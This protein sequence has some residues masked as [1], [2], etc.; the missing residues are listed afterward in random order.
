MIRQLSSLALAAAL[1]APIALADR[2][3]RADR[4]RAKLRASSPTSP[5]PTRPAPSF[6][7]NLSATAPACAPARRSPARRDHQQAQQAQAPGV[8]QINLFDS[9]RESYF[10]TT[11]TIPVGTTIQ[12]FI[13]QPDFKQEWGLEALRVTED[14]SPGFSLVLP[15]ISTLG[16]FWQQGL[17]TYWIVVTDPNGNQSMSNTDFGTKGFY[18]NAHHTTQTA[19]GSTPGGNST[20]ATAPSSSKSR[21]VS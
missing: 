7:P 8:I 14:L 3:G 1:A 19:P 2:A 5:S 12:A 6:A 13:A 17:T 21:A 11:Q 16:D 15:G 18:R 20:T 9:A 10:V 4:S